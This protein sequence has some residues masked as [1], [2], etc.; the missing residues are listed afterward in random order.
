MRNDIAR[1]GESIQGY[2]G[3]VV[4][5]AGVMPDCASWACEAVLRGECAWWAA[6]RIFAGY[7][8][9]RDWRLG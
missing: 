6:R 8:R 2:V 4:F 1:M 3:G 5:Q 7:P 9:V